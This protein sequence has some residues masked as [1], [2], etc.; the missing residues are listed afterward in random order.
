MKLNRQLSPGPDGSGSAAAPTENS[1]DL[2]SAELELDLTHNDLPIPEKKEE[3]EKV[4]DE[5]GA[6]IT[7]PVKAAEL[8]LEQ[9][10]SADEEAKKIKLGEEKIPAEPSKE[11]LELISKF[12]PEQKADYDAG[13]IDINGEPVGFKGDDGKGANE[14]D[15]ASS[16]IVVAK[17]LGYPEPKE[18]SFEAFKEVQATKIEE[19]RKEIE[20]KAFEDHLKDFPAKEQLF[21]RGFRAGLTME[22]IQKPIDTLNSLMALSDA[23][24]LAASLKARGLKEDVIQYQIQKLVEEEKLELEVAPIRNEL[25]TEKDGQEQNLLE[26]VAELEA[27]LKT[28]KEDAIKEDRVTFRKVLDTIPELM[29]TKLS[30]ANKEV[31]AAKYENGGYHDLLTNHKEMAE[32]LLWKEYRKEAEQSLVNRAL[33]NKRRGEQNTIHNIPPIKKGAGSSISKQQPDGK[34]KSEFAQVAYAEEEF[35]NNNT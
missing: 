9:Q 7:D 19:I 11:E 33:E 14:D 18:D 35:I 27:K 3:V 21:F 13:K 20:L 17:E 29:G 25:K 30:K 4:Y 22:Q 5:D 10:A 1:F 28:E 26:Q 23:D 32:Y 8:K 34:Q 12:T 16:W 2:L 6:E 31:V 24:L 15:D